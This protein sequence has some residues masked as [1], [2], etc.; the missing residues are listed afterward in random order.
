MRLALI[1]AFAA[2]AIGYAAIPA[3]AQKAP[4]PRPTVTDIA[5]AELPAEA[6][7][8]IALIRKLGPYP[9]AK[10]GAIFGNREGMLPTQKRGYYHEYTVRTPGERTR[11]ARRIV[12]GAGGEIFYSADHYT[13]FR[14]VR[15]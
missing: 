12:T 3:S 5:A 11:G 7:E 14:R 10:D 2:F 15:E 6:R 1:S 4:A 13:T 8:T 9:Y